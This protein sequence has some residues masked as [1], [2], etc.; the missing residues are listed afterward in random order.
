MGRP[1]AGRFSQRWH[2]IRRSVVV[3]NCENAH[4]RE[5]EDGKNVYSAVGG[6]RLAEHPAVA[7][8]AVIASCIRSVE[9][10]SIPDATR[11]TPHRVAEPFRALKTHGPFTR[12]QLTHPGS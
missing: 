6:E 7:V 11:L 1:I 5:D 10:R 2:R 3:L 9:N 12:R 4:S 8:C